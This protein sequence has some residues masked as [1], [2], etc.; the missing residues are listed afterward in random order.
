[1]GQIKYSP[2]L[3]NVS[4]LVIFPSIDMLAAARLIYEWAAD[5]LSNT[6]IMHSLTSCLHFL[7]GNLLR[8]FS[9]V[10]KYSGGST[11]STPPGL[12]H[13]YK[14]TQVGSAINFITT[15]MSTWAMMDQCYDIRNFQHW[16]VILRASLLI[17]LRSSVKSSRV[18]CRWSW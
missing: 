4:L 17:S 1:M 5:K 15:S 12:K 8:N 9:P 18:L 7:S 11:A 6:P 3:W 14:V 2:T 13:C 10:R 16:M